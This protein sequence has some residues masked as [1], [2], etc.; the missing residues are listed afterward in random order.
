MTKA[1]RWTLQRLVEEVQPPERTA[2]RGVLTFEAAD[3]AEVLMEKRSALSTSS[4]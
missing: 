4:S 3:Q 1:G 2:L